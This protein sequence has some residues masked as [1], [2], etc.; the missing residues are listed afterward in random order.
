MRPLLWVYCTSKGFRNMTSLLW[1]KSSTMW[2]LL[3]LHSTHAIFF[4][5]L[6]SMP[7]FYINMIKQTVSPSLANK[8]KDD[9]YFFDKCCNITK[10]NLLWVSFKLDIT[11]VSLYLLGKIV[12]IM[13][14]I[15][16]ALQKLFQK[17][18]FWHCGG[19]FVVVI[20]CL[21]L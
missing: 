17:C 3:N 20:V 12:I 16:I 9:F 19:Y 2:Q 14:V 8:C 4:P 1:V 13:M 5:L 21:L 10:I 6:I 11:I 15:M 18:S 7:K